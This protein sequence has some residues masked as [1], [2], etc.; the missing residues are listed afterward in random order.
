MKVLVE[1]LRKVTQKALECSGYNQEETQVI[2]EILLY[3]QLRGSNQGVVKLIGNGMPKSKTAVTVRVEKETKLS[4]VINGGQNHGMIVLKKATGMAIAK[5]KAHG[6]GLVGTNNTS[7]ST[8][9]IGY[10]ADQ[11]AKENLIGLV[12]ATS[13][14][15][16]APHNSYEAMYGTNPIAIGIPTASDP[17]VLDMATSAIAYYGLVEAKTAKRSIPADIGY[18]NTGQSTTHPVEIIDGGAIRSFDRGHKG[19]GLAFMVQVLAGPFVSA[20]FTGLADVEDNWG[21]LVIAI[22]PSLINYD[23][24]TFVN[25]VEKLITK[26]KSAK[27]LNPNIAVLLPGERGNQKMTESLRTGEVEIDKNLYQALL[28]V[29]GTTSKL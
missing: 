16:C 1:E 29:S 5:A 10:Y 11:I 19:S 4:A 17:V 27:R 20:A 22:D 3:A 28:K 23:M 21:N 2:L 13:P 9:S 14:P 15:S 25:N 8:G 7:T 24:Q 6:F 12:F 26:V 18:N